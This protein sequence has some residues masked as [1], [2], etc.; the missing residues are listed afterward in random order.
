MRIREPRKV[1]QMYEQEGG[2]GRGRN[3][4]F[5]EN[6]ELLRRALANDSSWHKIEIR[7]IHQEKSRERDGILT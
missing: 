4:G 6:F 3:V 7:A 2:G 5:L 1:A